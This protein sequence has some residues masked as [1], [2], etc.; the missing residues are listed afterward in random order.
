M[1]D[2]ACANELSDCSYTDEMRFLRLSSSD[3]VLEIMNEQASS[4]YAGNA[5][6][7]HDSFVCISFSVAVFLAELGGR[8]E[9][10][11]HMIVSSA[12][13]GTS[14]KP[15]LLELRATSSVQVCDKFFCAGDGYDRTPLD[16]VKRTSKSCRYVISCMP[17][18][19][20]ACANDGLT[21]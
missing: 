4:Q 20:P 11:R 10:G 15:Q 6:H 18:T 8:R 21:D 14:A 5:C 2:D 19:I 13:S 3:R 9:E 17:E 12:A 7:R 1:I 16:L